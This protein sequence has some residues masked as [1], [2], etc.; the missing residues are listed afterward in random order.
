MRSES[1]LG[2]N[3]VARAQAG[4]LA[5]GG[6]RIGIARW[7][8]PD[9]ALRWR[10]DGADYHIVIDGHTVVVSL[11]SEFGKVDL[12]RASES[13]IKSMITAAGKGGDDL[14][15]EQVTDSILDWRDRNRNRRLNGAEDADY[16]AAGLPYGSRD[17]PFI[18]IQ[19]LTQ[20]RGMTPQL[21]SRL[22]PLVTVY[23]GRPQIDPGTAPRGVLLG[24]PG[25]TEGQVDAYLDS[26]NIGAGHGLPSA[27]QLLTTEANV[28]SAPLWRP[29]RP[30]ERFQFLPR[31]EWARRW[32]GEQRLCVRVQRGPPIVPGRPIARGACPTQ[33]WPG[34][35]GRWRCRST[36]AFPSRRLPAGG[37]LSNEI[38][39]Y[40]ANVVERGCFGHRR[41]GRSAV[42]RDGCT[43][44]GIRGPHPRHRGAALTR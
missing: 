31:R 25:V 43:G 17:G 19:E 11:Q 38:R 41:S 15:V 30:R 10:V 40:I 20:L 7:L 5:E 27:V 34:T 22:A 18:S 35:K 8:E 28:L 42:R 33:C 16:A 12:N 2:S 37:Y 1:S 24:L 13:L 6:L 36:R 21:F 39:H 29:S 9:E 44:H 32:Q 23:A 3:L 14:A 26:R 4:A